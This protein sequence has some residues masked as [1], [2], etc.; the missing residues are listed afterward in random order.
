MPDLLQVAGMEFIPFY[1]AS[2]DLAALCRQDGVTAYWDVHDYNAVLTVNM[3]HRSG[4]RVPDDLSVVGRHDTPW[5]REC[6]PPLTTVSINPRAVAAE[7][8]AALGEPHEAEEALRRRV[9]LVPPRLVVRGS[10]GRARPER[11]SAGS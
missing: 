8:T 11:A 3:C 7:I 2:I 4:L 5:A 1:M 10:S 9:R 6:H